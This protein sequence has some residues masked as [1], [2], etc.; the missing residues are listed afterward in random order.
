MQVVFSVAVEATFPKCAIIRLRM[1]EAEVNHKAFPILQNKGSYNTNKCTAVLIAGSRAEGLAMEKGWGHPESDVDNMEFYGGPL[2]VHVPQG[3]QTPGCAAL[4]YRPEGCPPAYCKIE[5]THVHKL[6]Q[7]EWEGVQLDPECVHRSEGVN[8]LHTYNT[9]RQIP[10]GKGMVEVIGPAAQFDCGL[11]ENITSLL[12][13]DTHPDIDRNYLQRSRHGWPSTQQLEII[14]KLRMILVLVG[15]KHS[16]EFPLQARLSWSPS[17]IILMSELPEYIKQAYI[18][19]KYTFKYFMK[20]FRGPDTTGDGRSLVGS[21]HIKTVFLHHLESKTP[22]MIGSQLGLIT[23][24]LCDF[25]NYLKAGKLP[26]HFLP[27]CNLLATVGPEER[28]ITHNV[29]NYILSDPLRA[30]LSCPTDPHDIYGEVRPDTLVAA[31]RRV[32]SQPTSVES[33]EELLRLL[34]CLDE[35]R[36]LLYQQQQEEDEDWFNMV[37]DRPGLTGLVDMLREQLQ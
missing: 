26:H 10:Q 8:W 28:H 23:G 16:N 24:L 36:K 18:A 11:Q 33:R 17:E 35:R 14:K 13:N 20:L 15:H 30:I 9:V 37:F 29:I 6:M 34:S 27:N 7:L 21:Y 32:S 2:G 5:V 31:F 22:T 25:D 12:C 4:K 3:R 1:S 19:I